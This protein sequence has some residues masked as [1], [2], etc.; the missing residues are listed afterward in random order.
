MGHK[1]QE[2]DFHCVPSGFKGPYTPEPHAFCVVFSAADKQSFKM[3][4][5]V[6]ERLWM[7]EVVGAKAVILVANKTDLVRGRQ[8]TTE[9]KRNVRPFGFRFWAKLKIQ[10]S[11]VF[12]RRGQERRFG[13]RLQIHRD[14]RGHQ[15]QR[16]RTPRRH[17]GADPTQ[18]P[19]PREGE[20]SLQEAELL[21]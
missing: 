12:L 9:G 2:S 5:S 17:P 4:E 13:A 15:P 11:R 7:S 1:P 18:A 20:E 6:L 19:G 10:F 3:A 14:V 21:A 8:V 16:G